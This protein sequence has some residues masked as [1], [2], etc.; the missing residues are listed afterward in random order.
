MLLIEKVPQ[1]KVSQR[2]RDPGENSSEKIRRKQYYFES[3]LI[4]HCFVAPIPIA[5]IKSNTRWKPDGIT[6][7]GGRGEG[8][9]L[10]SL[11]SPFGFD[12]D[13]NQTVVVADY[14]NHRVVEFR[15]GAIRG[16]LVAAGNDAGSRTDQLNYPTDVMLDIQADR[17]FICDRENQRIVQWSR[18]GGKRGTTVIS[19]VKCFGLT[20]DE[21][22]FLYVSDLEKHEVTRWWI[23]DSQGTSVA[24]GNGAGF[25]LDQLDSP[26]YVFV[27]H[28]YS[29]YVSDSQ[30]HR[31][32]KWTRGA[33][34]GAIVAGGRG[35]GDALT[36]LSS[37]EGIFVDQ[38][39]TVYVADCGNNR[40]MRWNLGATQ[41]SVIAGGHDYGK[42]PNQLNYPMDLS[43]GLDGS[44]YVVDSNNNRV[45]KFAVDQNPST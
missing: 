6:V 31:V 12:I 41:G 35:D 25:R 5:N 1:D 33:K 19:N 43:I 38:L 30:N 20:M 23:G 2:L 9:D 36:Q 22:G 39:G 28:H 18:H 24:G 45:Q 42:E 3:F 10:D 32:M 21:R 37:P 29:V 44:L 34:Q 4:C 8:N 13:T 27:D 11:N 16:E 7:A 17:M 15:T 40:L 26:H 14:Y